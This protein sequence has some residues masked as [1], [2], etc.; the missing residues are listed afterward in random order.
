LK[1]SLDG[2]IL[3]Y[4]SASVC[5]ILIAAGLIENRPLGDGIALLR[6]Q[7]RDGARMEHPTLGPEAG[8][9]GEK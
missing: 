3:I 6:Y 8:E 9:T 4:G 7:A 5:H 1:I 2:N